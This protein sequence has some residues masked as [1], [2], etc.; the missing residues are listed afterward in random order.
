MGLK[1]QIRIKTIIHPI[2]SGY[3]KFMPNKPKST[4]QPG[5]L[6]MIIVGEVLHDVFHPAMQNIAESADGIDFHIF[7]PPQ[8]VKLGT[9]D[10]VMGVQVILGNS[11][12]LHGRP[13]LIVFD[14]RFPP[15]FLLDF[16]LLLP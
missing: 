3:N 12:G 4:R 7:V 15:H 6:K 9:V 16:P 10:I 5:C 1:P 8:P 14:H 11:A 2:S 13:Q